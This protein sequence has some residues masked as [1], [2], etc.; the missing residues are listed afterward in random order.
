MGS[1]DDPDQLMI[2]LE[3]EAASFYCK[4]LQMKDFL[5]ETGEELVN[6]V[7]RK[8]SGS[9]MVVD[10]GGENCSRAVLTAKSYNFYDQKSS[11][12]S[13]RGTV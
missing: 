7:L 11:P 3:P 8:S 4:R 10:N 1:P 6:E 5:G 12:S 9:Y 13:R 2:A